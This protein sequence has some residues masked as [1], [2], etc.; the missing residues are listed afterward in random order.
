MSRAEQIDHFYEILQDLEL[1]L[2]GRRRLADCH[3]KLDWPRRGVYFFFEPGE[4]RAEGSGLR[5]VRVGTHA[6]KNNSRSTLWGRLRTHRGSLKTEGGNHRASVFRFHVG[7]ATLRREG[8]EKHYSTWMKV[9]TATKEIKSHE[10]SIE[11]KVSEYIR[12]MPFLWLKVDDPPGPASKRA[13]FEQNSISLLSNYGKLGTDLIDPPSKRWLGL[14]SGN[15]KICRS[16]LWNVDYV[17]KPWDADF[18]HDLEAEV[19][20]A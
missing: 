17:D 11:R 10:H 19:R 16:G 18:L 13:Y 4:E 12:A 5:V 15:P 20:R 3:G 9:S 6:L 14:C 8:L 2:G 1:R 7:M